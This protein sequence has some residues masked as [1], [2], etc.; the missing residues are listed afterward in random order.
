MVCSVFDLFK[1]GVGPSSSHTMGPMTAACRFVE[2]LRETALL[3]RDGA[4]RGRPLRLARPDRQGPRHRP[5]DPARPVGRA[6]R[7]DR[8]RRGR[9]DGRARSA[10]P[11]GS[12]SAARTRSASTRPRDLRFLQRERL[13]HHSNGMRFT[14]F[15]AAGGDAGERSL[16]FGRRRRRRRRGG[17][18]AQRPARRRLGRA[19]RLSARPTSCSRIAEREGLTI[20]EIARANER[21]ALSD[22][23]IDRPARRDRRRRCRPASTAASAAGGILPGGLNVKRR[24]PALYRL[25]TE[26]AERALSG[27]ADRDRLG[28]SLG[29]RG[30]RG[31]C[32]RRQGRHRAD[33]RRRRHRPGGAALLPALHARVRPTRACASSCS[34]PR[35]SARC[36]RRMPRSRAPRSAARARSAS[37]ARWRRRG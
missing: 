21:A 4:G 5:R 11:G 1:I 36:S 18:G 2:G 9:R 19:L 14:A 28:Q 13:P 37:P 27:S 32:G 26:R 6:A 33:Q 24:A 31:E 8:P 12:A 15:D 7:P 17:G 10:R 35:R 29:A 22:E 3:E 23:E 20:A 16:L 34:P 25:L 30:Q